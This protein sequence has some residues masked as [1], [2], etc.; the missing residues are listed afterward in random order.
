MSPT[1]IV[2]KRAADVSGVVHTVTA[3]MLML[4]TDLHI[5]D[6]AKHMSRADFVRNSMRAIQESMPAVDGAS[7]PDLVRDDSSSLK[8]GSGSVASM[9]P[10]SSSV[11]TKP[12]VNPVS[13]QARSASAP[14]VPTPVIRSD[15]GFRGTIQAGSTTTFSS[16]SYSKAWEAEAENALKV[17]RLADLTNKQDIYGQVRADKILLPINGAVN[18][19]SM[20]S[21]S[22][23]GGNDPNTPMRSPAL[24]NN[25][26]L[27]AL[28]RGSIRGAQSL[29]NHPYNSQSQ[30]SQSDGRLSPA[31]S[32]GQRYRAG[33]YA[34][35]RSRVQADGIGLWERR[36]EHWIRF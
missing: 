13:A 9:A 10:S 36:S 4:N 24:K 25:D 18:R 3:A 1:T 8:V 7:T 34:H 16:F 35:Q 19:Q 26:R 2:G 27:N 21:L 17:G 20:I 31:S 14:V 30:F 29:L 15:S 33:M 11:R 5:A 23:S 28:K 32:F 12:P 22:G 6:M